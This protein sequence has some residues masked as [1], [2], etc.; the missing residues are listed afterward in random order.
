MDDKQLK[1]ER[2]SSPALTYRTVDSGDGDR[3]QE[4][5]PPSPAPTYYTTGGQ[6]PETDN[7]TSSPAPTYHTVDL[8]GKTTL[9]PAT[10]SSSRH[11]KK[12]AQELLK[13]GFDIYSP[14]FDA[15]VALL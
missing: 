10:A 5:D 6:Q 8:H 1:T 11:N 4:S 9:H 2:A 12:A 3:R 14:D 13:N 15:T 7:R